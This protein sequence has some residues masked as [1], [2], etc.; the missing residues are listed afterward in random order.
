MKRNMKA[1]EALQS[2]PAIPVVL[3]D[4]NSLW[5]ADLYIEVTKDIPN[6]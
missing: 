4:E 5:G 2:E 3:S 6:A 1:I